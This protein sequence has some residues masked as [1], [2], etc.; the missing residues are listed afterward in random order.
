MI[1]DKEI[2]ITLSDEKPIVEKDNP[3]SYSLMVRNLP[4]SI[5]DVQLQTEY[6]GCMKVKMDKHEDT[7]NPKG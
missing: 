4:Y 7:G 3:P 6:T 1:D 2:S 5:T